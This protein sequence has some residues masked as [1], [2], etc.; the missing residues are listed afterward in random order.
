MAVL[1]HSLEIFGDWCHSSRGIFHIF[2][3]VVYTES[4]G[5]SCA[6]EK[7]DIS[8]SREHLGFLTKLFSGFSR[9]TKPAKML[10]CFAN[11]SRTSRVLQDQIFAIFVFRENY[12]FRE[13]RE[14]RLMKHNGTFHGFLKIRRK[15]NNQRYYNY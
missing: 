7:G 14:I 11:L 10:P 1:Q 15:E 5:S 6:A 2:K 13:T 12:N 9:N 8:F 3:W 4:G